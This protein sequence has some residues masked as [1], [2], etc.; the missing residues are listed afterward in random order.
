MPYA[1]PQ[2]RAKLLRLV[3]NLEFTTNMSSTT[4]QSVATILQEIEQAFGCVPNLFQAYAKYPPLLE[5]NWLKVKQILLNGTLKREVKEAIALRV[6]YDNK[7]NYC[8]TAHTAFLHSLGITEE[9]ISGM[10]QG[11]YPDNFSEQDIAL[12]NFTREAN[13]TWH[14]VDP[15]TLETLQGLG[16]EQAEILEAL[17]TMELFIAFNHFANVMHIESDF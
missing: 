7:C 1:L 14:Q 8:V 15:D 12:I 16:I 6:S 4:P 9:Q 5:A 3:P 2:I 10:L 17:G 11:I 13:Q